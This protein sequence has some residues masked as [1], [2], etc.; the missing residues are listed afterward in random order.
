[1][2]RVLNLIALIGFASSLFTRSADPIIPQIA[3][4]LHVEPETAALLSTAYALPYALVQPLL[5]VLADMFSKARLMLICLAVLALAS[6]ACAL[7]TSFEMLLVARVVAGLASGGTVPIAL[8]FVGDL[9]PVAGRQLAISRVLLALMTGNLLGAFGSGAIADLFDWRAVFIGMAVLG[10]ATLAVA[11]PGLHGVGKAGGRFDLSNI[12]PNY[13]TIF[14]HPLA[15]VCF[16]AV[17]LEGAFMYGV[18]PHMATLLHQAGETRASIAGLVIGGFG[19]GGA[20]YAFIVRWLLSRVGETWMMRTG[21]LAMGGCLL[22]IALRLPW[23]A[24]FANFVVLGLAFYVLHAVIQV[25][26]SELAPAARGSALALHSFFFFLGQ[27]AGPV[28]Y[29]AA[30]A[31]VGVTPILVFGALVLALTGFVCAATL[32]RPKLSTR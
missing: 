28:I 9:V 13:R 2:T 17:L 14:S 27:A 7:A 25:Y 16:G 24:E 30:F 20:A 11:I 6:L 26:A 31:L 12:G 1:M 32:R 22:V 4:G 3:V 5:G 29:S 15:K 19:V 8:A 18:F 21:G 23:P 10:F